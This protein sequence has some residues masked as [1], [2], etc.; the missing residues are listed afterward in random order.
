MGHLASQDMEASY[1]AHL[2]EN[3][4]AKTFIETQNY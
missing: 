3:V 1:L 4:Y 2:S